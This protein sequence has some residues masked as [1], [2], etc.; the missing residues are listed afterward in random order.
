[1]IGYQYALLD[2]AEREILAY[3]WHPSG[4]SSILDPHLHLGPAGQIRQRDLASAH[5][6]TGMISLPDIIQL[7]IE[8]FGV[9]PRVESWREVVAEA[10][11]NR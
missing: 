10:R 8:S 3:H 9:V 6:P 7:A 11:A 5:L 4:R 2:A 1:M